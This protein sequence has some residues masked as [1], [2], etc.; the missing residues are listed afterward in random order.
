VV[1][2]DVMP[3]LDGPGGSVAAHEAVVPPAPALA[4]DTL[5]LHF[6]AP[7]RLQ[8]NGRRATAE[9]FTQRKL[10]T[11]LIRRIALIHEFHGA[12][13]LPLDFKALAAQADGLGSEK[14]L[15]WRDWTR[16]SSRQQQKLDL[17]GV[18]GTWTL[19][20]DLSPFLPFLHLG[21]WLHV[22]KEAV[23]GLGAYRMELP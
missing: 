15:K 18:V 9:E 3:I 19:T 8:T 17:G 22:G 13:A 4:G 23:F 14:N 7:L 16:F 6:E 20:G 11:T 12:G 10:L 5:T 21:Q 1:G 2:D